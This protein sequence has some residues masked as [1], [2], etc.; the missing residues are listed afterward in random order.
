VGQRFAEDLVSRFGG[1]G[2]GC[3]GQLF[4][5]SGQIL[6]VEGSTPL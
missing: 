2:L 6:G 5:L 3:S 1:G 4:A